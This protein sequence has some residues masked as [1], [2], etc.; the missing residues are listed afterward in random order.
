MKNIAL[1]LLTIIIYFSIPSIYQTKAEGNIEPLTLTEVNKLIDEK[2]NEEKP[3]T[4]DELNKAL[5][6]LKDEKIANLEGNIS[7]V[8]DT[9]ALFVGALALGFAVIAGIISWLLNSSINK[10]LTEISEMKTSINST[11]DEIDS[12]KKDIDGVFEKITNYAKELVESKK[13]LEESSSLLEKK[14][15]QIDVLVTYLNTVEDITDSSILINQFVISSIQASKTVDTN[16]EIL[17][18]PQK[19]LEHVLFKLTQKLN[20]MNEF[21]DYDGLLTY[22]ESQYKSLQ[23]IENSISEQV[24]NIKNIDKE[25]MSTDEDTMTTYDELQHKFKEWQGYLQEIVDIGQIWKEHL[26]KDE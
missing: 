14:S 6:K 7:K 18:K 8:I 16:R 3:L 9:A 11:K 13:S 4:N 12:K 26:E 23:Q 5:L 20:L 10:K 1:I 24:M 19:N 21:D 25:F 22:F 15:S 17:K 2:I